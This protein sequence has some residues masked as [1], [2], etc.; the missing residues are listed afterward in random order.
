MKKKR[1]YALDS[2]LVDELERI[3]NTIK[4]AQSQ[5]LNEALKKAVSDIK[6]LNYNYVEFLKIMN[7]GN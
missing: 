5:I 4:V 1:N 3:S 2:E 7:G 6:K